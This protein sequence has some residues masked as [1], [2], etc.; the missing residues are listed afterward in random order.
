[1]RLFF[2]LAVIFVY[3]FGLSV[4]FIGPDEP[5]Y[6]EVA[7]EM[8]ERGDLITP[9]LGGY[10]WLEKPALLYWVEIASFHLFGVSEF[11]ARLFPALFGL[12]IVFSLYVLGIQACR[13]EVEARDGSFVP[14][15]DMGRRLAL[16][17]ASTIGIIVFS[18]G[19][20][21][22]IVLTFPITAALVGFF[23]YDRAAESNRSTGRIGLVAF[24]FFIGV[25]LLAKGLIGALFPLAIVGFYFLLS[26]RWPKRDFVLS[27]IWG[28]I[29]SAATASVWY[30]PMY[31]RHGWR[32]IDEFFIQHH[33]QRYTSNKYLHPQPI[34]FFLW[35]LPL[36]TIPWL[37]LFF[38]GF[39][40]FIRSM[41]LRI[42]NAAG[43][44]S[45]ERNGD[46]IKSAGELP[47]PLLLF[48]FAWMAVPLIFFS[49]SGS[50]L[51]G[52]I[53]PAVPAAVI[54][55]AEYSIRFSWARPGREKIIN[56]TAASTL[57]IALALVQFALPRFADDDSVKRLIAS[58]DSAGYSGSNVAGFI[59][60][61]HNAEF[62][63]AGRLLRLE[64][65]KQRR[66]ISPHQIAEE[67]ARESGRPL[68]VLVPLEHLRHIRES[69]LLQSDVLDENAELAIVAVKLR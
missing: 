5:R 65:G 14:A 68:L 7:R 52:Y 39:W 18:R 54:F 53:L 61:S 11:A 38:A 17:A 13:E 28:G 25:S 1:M 69:N 6:A 40:D 58:A 66:F 67:I 46:S 26:M 44:S 23:I 35:V 34:Y 3:L 55:A 62:Y 33:F 56:L 36:M 30:L 32:F 50:K 16:T 29:L 20:S 43:D 60:V 41:V 59:T 10:L 2:A 42:K 22:D 48:A 12:G 45:Q 51:P 57:A 19:A 8:F 24:Y 4:P 37:P 47:S 21:F 64:D 31:M 27:L 15:G 63:A 49:F 9:M